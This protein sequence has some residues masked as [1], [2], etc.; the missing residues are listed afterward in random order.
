MTNAPFKTIEDFRDIESI[1]HYA[2]AVAGG[3][4]PEH[5]LASLRPAS[6]DNARTPVHWDASEHAGF[7][8]GTPWMPVNPNHTEINAQ[9]ALA[10][11]DSVFHHYRRLIE[12]RHS[13]P[14][15]ATGDFT[16]RLP[17]DERV[18][19]FTRALDGDELLVLGN[20]TGDPVDVELQGWDGSE[21]A[22]IGAPGLALGPW[23]GKALRRSAA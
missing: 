12:L 13:L 11:P 2:Q 3:D 21:Q 19:A 9:A 8:S 22:L 6:R 15:I 5:V 10:D 14:V 20:F 16:M 7:T 17:D 18:Y 1:N 23:E 4:A